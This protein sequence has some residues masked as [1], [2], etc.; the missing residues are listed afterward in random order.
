[1]KIILGCIHAVSQTHESKKPPSLGASYKL[2]RD[3]TPF[4]IFY[5]LM[6]TFLTVE[7]LSFDI[8][9]I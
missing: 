2:I 9:I 5:L 6:I 3:L 1:M 7:I 8:F 4:L